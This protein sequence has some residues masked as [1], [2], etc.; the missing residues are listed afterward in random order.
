MCQRTATRCEFEMLT[1]PDTTYGEDVRDRGGGRDVVLHAESG[2]S[3]RGC[4]QYRGT[5]R[6]IE[7]PE[8]GR[9]SMMRPGSS[10]RR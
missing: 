1:I 2:E 9:R 4:D 5:S 10:I 7:M 6:E 8:R 3:R